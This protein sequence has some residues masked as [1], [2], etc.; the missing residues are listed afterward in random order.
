MLPRVS[1]IR[2]KP[3]VLVGAAACLL[4][5]AGPSVAGE[6]CCAK[7]KAPAA[8]AQST[9]PKTNDKQTTKPAGT[10]GFT[11]YLDEHGRPTAPPVGKAAEAP[12]SG[13]F[14]T[15][16]A[17]LRQVPSAGPAGG[18]KVDLEGRF[19]TATVATTGADGRIQLNCT[20]GE[21]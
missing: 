15:S 20:T 2:R 19:R 17:G 8:D 7:G 10:A 12:V 5:A 6:S 13:L 16:A 18:V 1:F 14:S 4:L 3:A 21:E 9:A 11:V